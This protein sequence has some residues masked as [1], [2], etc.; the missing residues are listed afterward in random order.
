MEY[1][2]IAFQWH[3]MK[4]LAVKTAEKQPEMSI[5]K[6]VEGRGLCQDP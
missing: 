2:R 1:R 3:D 5:V 6:Q 4:C